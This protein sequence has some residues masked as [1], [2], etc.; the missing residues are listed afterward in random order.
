MCCLKIN[1]SQ[2][3]ENALINELEKDIIKCRICNCEI[4]LH[5]CPKVYFPESDLELPFDKIWKPWRYCENG[6]F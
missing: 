4:N 3:Y 2:I 6:K 5:R 1:Q